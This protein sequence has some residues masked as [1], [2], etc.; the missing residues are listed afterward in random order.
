M[1][2][3]PQTLDSYFEVL[4]LNINP[5]LISAEYVSAIRRVAGLFPTFVPNVFGFESRLNSKSGRT[6]FAINMTAKGSE[7]LAWKLFDQSLPE[8]FRRDEKWSQVSHFF[9]KWGETNESPFADA[10]SV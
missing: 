5:T 4:E 7:L 9:Q 10:N 8:I 2:A 3:P 6:D 1:N